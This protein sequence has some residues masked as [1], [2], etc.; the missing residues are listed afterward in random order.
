[1]HS[2]VPRPRRAAR[3]PLLVLLALV[4]SAIAPAALASPNA[5]RVDG[6]APIGVMADHMHS[7]GE[8]MLS[9]RYMHMEMSPNY[10]G[11]DEI[12]VDDI[13]VP[14][15]GTYMVAPTDMK[16]DMHMFGMMFAPADC[17][18]LVAMIPFITKSMDHVRMDDARFT[19]DTKGVGDLKLS[20]LVRLWK[21]EHQNAHAQIGFSS[22]T[23]SIDETDD[24]LG[25]PDVPLPYPMQI[26]SGTFELILGGT[27]TGHHADLS[28]GGQVTGVIRLGENDRDYRLGNQYEVTGWGAYRLVDALSASFRLAWTQSFDIEGADPA[29]N[30]MMVPTADPDLRAGRRLDALFGLNF[31]PSALGERLAVVKGLRLAIEGGLPAY[32]SLDGPQLGESWQITTGIQYAF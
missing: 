13:L 10:V 20:A 21:S 17:V 7:K 28:W 18:T 6:H 2:Y 22:P 9:Y 3:P 4:S 30:P 5:S 27:Y 16:M 25:T 11:S 26:G 14:P 31:M 29:L 32:Q 12:D 24:I 1:M 19:T 15:P 23:G 8:W